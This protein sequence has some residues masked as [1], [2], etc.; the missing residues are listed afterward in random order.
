M[1]GDGSNGFF[2][3]GD[4]QGLV[5]ADYTLTIP[6]IPVTLGASGVLKLPITGNIT[7]LSVEPFTIHGGGG[8]AIPV[9]L[10]LVVDGESGGIG[11]P[12]SLPG[13]IHFTVHID[14]LP[15]T[16]TVPLD[17]S[18]EPIQVPRITISE[19]PLNLTLGSDSTMLN[20]G[21]AGNIGGITVPV[22]HLDA[23][24]GYGNTTDAPSSGFF[25]SGDGNASG[26][27]NVGDTISG[28]WN[29]GSQVSGFENYGGELLSGLTNLGNTMSGIS[30]TNALGLAVAGIVSGVNNIGSRLS[31]L[32]LN[33]TVP[34]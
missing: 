19:I 11:I 12:I 33:G 21:I 2:W 27:G 26:F 31:G 5:E 22:F 24:P 3:R 25:N 23:A 9:N 1:S 20:V 17:S 8:A 15:I 28:L 7:G 29:V 34:Y 16:I 10:D 6:A 18:L 4:G 13:D 14:G 32:F 30:N